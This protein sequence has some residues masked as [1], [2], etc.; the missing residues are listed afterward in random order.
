MV[1][2][3]IHG[4]IFYNIPCNHKN[5]ATFSLIT[6]FGLLYSILNDIDNGTLHGTLL[7]F[8]KIILSDKHA[9][10]H[11]LLTPHCDDM[12]MQNPVDVS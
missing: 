9:K 5:A 12:K 4:V 6:V 1:P 2:Y 11:Q 10:S 7:A 3:F 8:L